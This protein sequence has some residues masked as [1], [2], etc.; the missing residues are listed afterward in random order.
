MPRSTTTLVGLLCASA[1]HAQSPAAATPFARDIP[2]RKLGPIRAASRD[3]LGPRIVVRGL[4]N[5]NVLVGVFASGIGLERRR[6]L[7]FDSTLKR[8]AQVR[9]ST[10]PPQLASLPA[11]STVTLDPASQALLVLNAEGKEVRVMA[12]PRTQDFSALTG[13]VRIPAFDRAGR[14]VYLGTTPPPP[15]ARNAQNT[16]IR[17]PFQPDSAPIVRADFDTRRVDTLAKI[18][19]ARTLQ[20]D[21]SGPASNLTMNTTFDMTSAADQWALLS[22]GTIAIV[23]VQDY[24][25]DWIDP[26]GTRRATPKMPYEWTRWSDQRKQFVID[27]MKPTLDSARAASPQRTFQTA[28]GPVKITWTFD[29]ISP[30]KFSDYDYPIGPGSVKADLDGNLWVVPRSTRLAQGGGLLYD[31]INRNGEIIER[32]QFPKGVVLAGFGPR[33]TIYLNRV[34]GNV[35]FLERAS[36]H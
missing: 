28:D 34:D 25:I 18:R 4:S 35:G 1:L 23:R 15:A 31:V 30:D 14:L 26:D 11:D 19:I 5:G 3:T 7:L 32:V 10:S 8:I 33:N 22:D 13:F 24:H 36:R 16:F 9:D 20:Y 6:V 2:I 17:T 27:S 29:V 21:V 12:L